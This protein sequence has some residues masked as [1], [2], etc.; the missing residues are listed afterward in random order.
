MPD[1]RIVQGDQNNGPIIAAN[2]RALPRANVQLVALVNPSGDISWPIGS[3]GAGGDG[4]IVDGANAAIKATVEQYLRSNPLAVVLKNASGDSYN[5]NEV[6]VVVPPVTVDKWN[7]TP[8]QDSVHV[9]GGLTGV[10]GDVTTLPKPGST[11]P[12]SIAASVPVSF[13][14]QIGVQ[15]VGGSVGAQ[16][17]PS[18]DF[19]MRIA[20]ATVPLGISGDVSTKPAAG[21]TWPVSLAGTLPVAEQTKI[22]V[23]VSA[24]QTGVTG[25]VVIRQGSPLSTAI[26]G[27]VLLRGTSPVSQQG[28]VG[29]QIVGGGTNRVSISGDQLTVNQNGAW[30]TAVTGDVSTLPKAG[31]T[32][33]VREQGI[34]GV[35]IVGGGTNRVSISGDQ[36]SVIQD[37]A[38]ATAITG[39][40]LLRGTVLTR[41]QGK[42]GAHVA[43][44]Q[45][46]VTGDVS[47]AP[48][49]GQT[50]PVS[51]AGVINTREQNKIGTHVASGVVGISGDVSTTPAANQT[52]PVSIAGILNTREQ[53]KIGVHVAAG[54]I[55]VT[56]DVSIKP[57][58]TPAGVY[59]P[60]SGDMSISDGANKTIKS[61]VKQYTRSNPVAVVLV[62]A[63]GDAYNGNQ[64]SISLSKWN[65]TP[66]QDAVHLN[67][68]LVGVTGDVS[69][70][71]KVGSTWP[72][73]LAGTVNTAEQV[74]VGTHVASGLIGVTGD[75]S[76]TDGADPTIECTVRDYTRSNPLAVVLTNASGDHY[77][78][79][80]P[81]PNLSETMSGRLTTTG[82]R[83][84]ASAAAGKR[85]YVTAYDF[86][87][88]ADYS[89]PNWAAGASG[90]ALSPQ[91]ILAAREGV[92]KQVPGPGYIFRTTPGGNLSLENNGNILRW[93][94]TYFTGDS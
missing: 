81:M 37:G 14:G 11:W 25:D 52:W 78:A 4:A 46:G 36:L 76:I 12:V 73:S 55:G 66:T 91:W 64:T 27:D 9:D 83:V 28:V 2:V 68:G 16:V 49:A 50:W 5:A 45:I 61:T 35:Q 24:G 15:I 51:V 59:H 42:I 60:V 34:I 8:T 62:N 38:W 85:L 53:G 86:Q 41:E 43:A 72:V 1:V 19:P 39:D 20:A 79:Q 6:S 93:S 71:P 80:S 33:P 21:Q 47:T 3:S 63:S 32:W 88:E 48:A 84:V 77:N 18:G 67:S 13:S 92:A 94:V 65:L 87:A 89:Y 7:L 69:T 26:T 54:I 74:K 31:Q 40:V 58:S 30:A 22:G 10:T 29:V 75:R 57:G 56:G 70:V 82:S 17:A 90:S 44:G 23:H